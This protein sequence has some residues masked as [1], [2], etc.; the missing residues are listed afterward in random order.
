MVLVKGFRKALDIR[1]EKEV[2]SR[3][4][5]SPCFNEFL[6]ILGEL[7]GKVIQSDLRP[8]AAASC[9]P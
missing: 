6:V 8:Y 9:V 5:T 3:N 7:T 1:L 2:A 4:Q